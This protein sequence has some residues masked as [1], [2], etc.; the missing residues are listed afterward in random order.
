[1]LLNDI[2]TGII[3][4]LGMLQA[5]FFFPAR[6]WIS[7]ADNL[8]ENVPSLQMQEIFLNYF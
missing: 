7:D 4:L 8:L 6:Q 2:L 1:M 5:F 3:W